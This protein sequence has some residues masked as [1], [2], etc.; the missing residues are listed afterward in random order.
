MPSRQFTRPPKEGRDNLRQQIT[1]L[2]KDMTKEELAQYLMT[3]YT[4]WDLVGIRD[5]L[6]L[7]KEPKDDG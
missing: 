2:S 1:E 7:K 5:D 3:Y 4:L 6:Q